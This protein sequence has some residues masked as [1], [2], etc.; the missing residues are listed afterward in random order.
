[1]LHTCFKDFKTFSFRALVKIS[2]ECTFWK[3]C[4]KLLKKERIFKSKWVNVLCYCCYYNKHC[5][6]AVWVYFW[7]YFTFTRLC[8]MASNT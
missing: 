1:M 5:M 7:N 6:V 2:E 8:L 3:I 4:K